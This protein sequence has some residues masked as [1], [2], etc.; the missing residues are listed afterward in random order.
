MKIGYY[1]FN[2][3]QEQ[4]NIRNSAQSAWN[5]LNNLHSMVLKG[6][7]KKQIKGVME[8]VKLIEKE[9]IENIREMI[10]DK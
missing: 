2:R 6:E 7:T 1:E 5:E 4:Q 10:D 9:A 8:A 3:L